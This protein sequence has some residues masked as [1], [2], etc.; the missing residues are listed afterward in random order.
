MV[1]KVLQY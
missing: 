1:Q